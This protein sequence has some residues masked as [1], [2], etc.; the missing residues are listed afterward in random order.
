MDR[1]QLIDYQIKRL[2]ALMENGTV[3]IPA[4]FWAGLMSECSKSLLESKIENLH[5]RCQWI[6]M[7]A[8]KYDE[9]IMNGGG[10]A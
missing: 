5:S 10:N 2:A 3:K 4:L 1:E 7:L 6:D 9:A 8:D